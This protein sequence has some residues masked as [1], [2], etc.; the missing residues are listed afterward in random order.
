MV[1]YSFQDFS[2]FIAS[3]ISFFDLNQLEIFVKKI[4]QNL[5]YNILSI[6][7]DKI[8]KELIKLNYSENFVKNYATFINIEEYNKKIK[9]HINTYHLKNEKNKQSK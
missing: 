5:H 8:Q 1:K 2:I 9:N 7:N 6:K 3:R 4:F